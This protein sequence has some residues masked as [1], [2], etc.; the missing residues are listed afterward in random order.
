MVPRKSKLGRVDGVPMVAWRPSAAEREAML[1][2]A[3]AI[4]VNEFSRRRT[5]AGLPIREDDKPQ[6]REESGVRVVYDEDGP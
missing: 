5:L 1:A 2:A 6:G 3:G 4:S